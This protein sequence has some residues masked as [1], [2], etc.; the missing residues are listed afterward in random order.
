M[1][2]DAPRTIEQAKKY[3]YNR[4][5]GNPNGNRYVE[6]RCAYKVWGT[7]R[8]MLSYQ[9][10]RKNGYG[11]DDLYCKQHSKKVTE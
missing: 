2:S 5:S 10:H 3:R 11:P 4:W 7:G 6:G 9:C 1:M 8:S